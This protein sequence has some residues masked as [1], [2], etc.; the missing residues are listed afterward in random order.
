MK[1]QRHV[2][3]EIDKSLRQAADQE[4]P[5]QTH[6]SKGK[7]HDCRQDDTRDGDEQRV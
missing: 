1:Q 2:S 5:R 7:A 3:S 4:V 6:Y